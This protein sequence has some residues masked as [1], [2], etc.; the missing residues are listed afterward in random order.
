MI[1]DN[2]R[3]EPPGFF[4]LRRVA[5][6]ALCVSA[7]ACAGMLVALMLVTEDPGTSYGQIIGSYSLTERNLGWSLLVFGLAIVACAGITTWLITLYSSFRVAGPLYRFSR[8]LEM[9]IEQ[10][11]GS[12]LPIRSADQLH[13]EWKA[14]NAGVSAVRGHYDAL[15]RALEEAGRSLQ[16]GPADAAPLSQAIARLRE[17]ERRARL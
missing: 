14:L 5:G 2:G 15:R 10:W 4:H 16:T 7:A 13:R 1:D 3:R 8:N 11:P 6:I 9:G 12:A 17:I